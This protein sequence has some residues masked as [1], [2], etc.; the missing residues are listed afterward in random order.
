MDGS[1]LSILMAGAMKPGY[2][3]SKKMVLE[4]PSEN[5]KCQGRGKRSV[6]CTVDSEI[7]IYLFILF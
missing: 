7:E 4:M 3:S 5:R 1:M 6:T 2:A